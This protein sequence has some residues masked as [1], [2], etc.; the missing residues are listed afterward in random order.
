MPNSPT[1]N[2]KYLVQIDRLRQVRA[3]FFGLGIV[4][5]CFSFSM[6]NTPGINIKWW[7]NTFAAL[8][9]RGL[10][11]WIVL[12]SL[13]VGVFFLVASAVVTVFLWKKK[14]SGS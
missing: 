12:P 5:I 11:H 13:G 9:D 8:R 3:W 7:D 2:L 10:L 1:S 6:V 14:R 4:T